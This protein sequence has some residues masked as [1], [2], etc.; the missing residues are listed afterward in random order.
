MNRIMASSSLNPRSALVTGADRGIGLELVKQLANLPKPPAH[1]FACGLSP[2]T[3]PGL[4]QVAEDYANVMVLEMD[5]TNT[6]TIDAAAKQVEQVTGQ[7]GLNLLINNAGVFKAEPKIEDVEAETMMKLYSVN[8]VGAAMVAKRFVPLIRTASGLFDGEDVNASR[9]AIVN[10]SSG[11]G[12]LKDKRS[13]SL[14]YSC[15]KTALNM[16]TK[17]LGLQLAAD[18]ILTMSI[19]P[20]WVGTDMGGPNANL[21]PQESVH[22]IIDVISTRTKEHSGL[23]F[24][25][26]GEL[27]PF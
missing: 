24:Q 17:D 18:H 5:V 11:L 13:S 1:V 21:S 8:T 26:N 22:S 16:L 7:N 27:I 3:S 15:T 9:A 20:G 14:S 4:K 25:F 2:S 10:I 23:F 12:S 6:G 19:N